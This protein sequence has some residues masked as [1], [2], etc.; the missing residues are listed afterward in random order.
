MRKINKDKKIINFYLKKYKIINKHANERRSE[1]N[2]SKFKKTR[3]REK[4]SRTLFKALSRRN[5]RQD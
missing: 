5:G 3:M 4:R 1:K 2:S